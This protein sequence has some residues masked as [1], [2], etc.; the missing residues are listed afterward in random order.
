[1]K[2]NKSKVGVLQSKFNW[3]ILKAIG[4]HQEI[5]CLSRP[6]PVGSNVKGT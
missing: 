5:P 1:M 6:L 3:E 2:L 4:K